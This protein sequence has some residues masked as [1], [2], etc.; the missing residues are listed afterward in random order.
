MSTRSQCD[1]NKPKSTEFSFRHKHSGCFIL[2]FK[3]SGLQRDIQKYLKQSFWNKEKPTINNFMKYY[4][5][6]RYLL[7][8]TEILR[9]HLFVSIYIPYRLLLTQNIN[10]RN[11]VI[12][13]VIKPTLEISYCWERLLTTISSS[14]KVRIRV[15]GLWHM[16]VAQ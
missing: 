7:E 5:M 10:Q 3:T 6:K 2:V 14:T 12:L 11:R 13:K 1:Q 16:R 4:Y 15:L 8:V 9:E